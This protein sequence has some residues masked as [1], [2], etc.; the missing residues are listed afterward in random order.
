MF[1][2]II[3][4]GDSA[5]KVNRLARDEQDFNSMYGGN[6][7]IVRLRDV[8]ED[9]PISEN[10]LRSALESANFGEAEIQAMVHLLTSGYANAVT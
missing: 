4:A 1:E 2:A 3:D 8:T 10:S 7:E 5:F 9:F 6:G